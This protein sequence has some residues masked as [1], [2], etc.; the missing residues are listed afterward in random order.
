MTDKLMKLFSDHLKA[1][2]EIVFYDYQL[3]VARRIFDALITNLRL[4]VNATKEDI[5]KLKQV[6]VPVEFSRQSGK[7]TTVVYV[8]EFIMTFFPRIFEQRSR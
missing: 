8:I 4:T 2:H 5:Q 1:K 6:E 3:E 7:T